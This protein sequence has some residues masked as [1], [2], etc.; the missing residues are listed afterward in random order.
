MHFL[1]LIP[2]LLVAAGCSAKVPEGLPTGTFAGAGK[3]RLCVAGEGEDLRGGLIVY[4]ADGAS[5]CSL[6]GK[7]AGAGDRW[8]LTPRGEGDCRVGLTLAG[9]RLKIAGLP[10]SCAYYCG[11]GARLTGKSFTRAAN[12]TPAVDMA[13]EALC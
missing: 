13:G 2:L 6:S 10:A 12:A 3:D 4:A 7:L 1:R 11:P 9:D 5:N 8:T